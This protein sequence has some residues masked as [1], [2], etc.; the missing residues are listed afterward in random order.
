MVLG[1]LKNFL[2]RFLKL[3][4][5]IFKTVLTIF[6]FFK[7][8]QDNFKNCPKTILKD[9]LGTIFKIVLRQF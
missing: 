8:S 5:T 7:L 6:K 1:N 2:K 3:S 9:C 4:W